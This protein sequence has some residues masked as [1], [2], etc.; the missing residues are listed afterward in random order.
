MYIN[1]EI[2]SFLIFIVSTYFAVK[3]YKKIIGI[4]RGLSELSIFLF[5]ISIGSFLSFYPLKKSI[6]NCYRLF[7][8]FIF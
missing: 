5:A 1:T 4:N 3:T 6:T 2:C 8:V 7:L